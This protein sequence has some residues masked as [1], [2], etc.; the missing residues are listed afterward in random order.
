MGANTWGHSPSI[1]RMSDRTLRLYLSARRVE[2]RHALSPRIPPADDYVE[3]T[4]DFAD[5]KVRNNLFP[6]SA[7]L[8]APD[9]RMHISYVSEPF[10]RAVC[11]CG[12]ITGELRAAI[13]RKD[14]DFTWALY[15]A[16]PDG[17]YFNLSYYLGRAS[18]ARNPAARQ[19]VTP[20]KVTTLPFSKTPLVGRQLSAG[21]RLLLLLTV[22]KNPHAQVNYGTG[23][24]VSDESVADAGMPLR[25]QWYGRSYIDVPLRDTR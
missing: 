2:Q 13:D 18:Y 22:N 7:W 6:G 10:E 8:D 15:E 3:Q 5:R 16:T 25:V 24:D 21:S 12:Q 11:V 20:G 17:R 1:A 19:L 9:G 23:K 4:V 14:F